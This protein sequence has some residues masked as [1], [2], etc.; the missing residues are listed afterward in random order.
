MNNDKLLYA[1]GKIDERYIS[2]ARPRISRPSA[3]LWKPIAAAVLC[4]VLSGITALAAT[5]ALQGF[6]RDILGQNGTVVG[7]AYEQ[8]SDEIELIITEA[9]NSLGVE[10]VLLHPD[11]APY[12]EIEALGIQRCEI[13]DGSGAIVREALSSE[14]A[15]IADGRISLRIPLEQLPKGS[16]LLAVSEIIGMKKADS[17][18]VLSGSWECAFTR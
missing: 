5:G 13:L 2:E 18:L 16:Y 10:M 17:P 3:F 9:T 15:E 11:R 8:A 7:T 14:M 6:F 1:L 4:I 12:S